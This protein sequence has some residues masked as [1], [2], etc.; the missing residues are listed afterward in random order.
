MGPVS[1]EDHLHELIGESHSATTVSDKMVS[2]LHKLAIAS[3]PTPLSQSLGHS[4][5]LDKSD[6]AFGID[7]IHC[8]R[9]YKN[10]LVFQ[11]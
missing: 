3:G 2:I 4:Q 11:Q 1:V 7:M 9:Y 8:C 10:M 5:T 6:A